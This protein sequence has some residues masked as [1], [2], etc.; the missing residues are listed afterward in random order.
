MTDTRPADLAGLLDGRGAHA[1]AVGCLEGLM[2]DQAERVPQGWDRSLH[3]L[4]MH[5]NFWQE[6]FVE[7]LMGR[8]APAPPRAADGWPD[9]AETNE[10]WA[11][12]VTRFRRGLAWVKRHAAESDLDERLEHWGDRTRHDAITVVALHNSYHL[13]QVAALRRALG[14]WPPPAGGDTW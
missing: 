3:E 11:E 12:S 7:R 4:L 9:P 8:E 5:M 10:S 2:P 1:D 6:L 13:G 14:A